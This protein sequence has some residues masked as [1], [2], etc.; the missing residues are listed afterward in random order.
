MLQE[1]SVPKPPQ[2]VLENV[3]A[4]PPNRETLGGTAYFIVEN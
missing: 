1:R 4:F 3:Y 2:L